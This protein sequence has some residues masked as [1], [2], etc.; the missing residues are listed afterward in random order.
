MIIKKKKNF[1][2]TNLLFNAM[3]NINVFLKGLKLVKQQKNLTKN[4]KLIYYYN[5]RFILFNYK[6][7]EKQVCPLLSLTHA[8][9]K[10]YCHI[11]GSH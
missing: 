8:Q 6:A 4:R 2:T 7:G 11:D 9:R 1:K 3:F 10:L 5:F